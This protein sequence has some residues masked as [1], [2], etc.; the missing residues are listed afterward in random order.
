MLALW[1]YQ[2]TTGIK[3]TE[4]NEVFPEKEEVEKGNIGRFNED[5]SL[6]FKLIWA[7]LYKEDDLVT[8]EEV[9]RLLTFEKI[10]DVAVQVLSFALESMPGEEEVEKKVTRMVKKMKGRS[11]TGQP[12]GKR[13]AEQE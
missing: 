5:I 12:S 4:L 11:G 3:L 1:K 6:L 10:A 7:G 2:Q 13:P 8:P 9:A